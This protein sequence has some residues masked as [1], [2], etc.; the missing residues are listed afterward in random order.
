[1]RKYTNV[2]T[3]LKPET[4][5]IDLDTRFRSQTVVETCNQNATRLRSADFP[6][7]GAVRIRLPLLLAA[8]VRPVTGRSLSFGTVALVALLLASQ[9]ASLSSRQKVS[10]EF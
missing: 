10:R 9:E 7:G 4:Y 3:S 8:T 2:T 5:A 6:A 1:M